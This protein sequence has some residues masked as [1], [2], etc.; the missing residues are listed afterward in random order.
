MSRDEREKQQSGEQTDVTPCP[1]RLVHAVASAAAS[2]TLLLALSRAV[3]DLRLFLKG[4]QLCR[5]APER[6]Y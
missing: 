1:L 2:M 6:T 4:S 5:N 3:Y